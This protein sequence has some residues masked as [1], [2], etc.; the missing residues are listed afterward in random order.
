MTSKTF[1]THF[2]FIVASHIIRG[3]AKN[4]LK[5]IVKKKEQEE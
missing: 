3:D 2:H 1:G 5:K 4:K